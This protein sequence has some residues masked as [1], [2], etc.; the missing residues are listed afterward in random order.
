MVRRAGLC[1]ILASAVVLCALPT[2][3]SAHRTPVRGM[4]INKSTSISAAT[5][6]CKCVW[7]W[8]TVGLKPGA[9]T[10]STAIRGCQLAMAPTCG[11]YIDLYLGDS[12]LTGAQGSCDSP[13]GRCGSTFSLSYRV[14]RSGIYY[15]LVHGAGAQTVNYVMHIRG[16][17]YPLAC[18]SSC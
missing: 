17:I 2:S 5:G 16:K 12:R 11:M 10:I 6:N 4:K 18:R 15:L 7:Q 3:A 14:P 13:Q 1:L 8:F 9:L